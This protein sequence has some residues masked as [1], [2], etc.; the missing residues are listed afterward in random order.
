LSWGYLAVAVIACVSLWTLADRWWPATLFLFGPRWVLLLPLAALI[1]LAL[2]RRA[3]L[4]I[5]LTIGAA[6]VLFPVMGLRLG[7][8]SR[9]GSD[10][11]AATLRVVTFNTDGALGAAFDL[12]LH[13]EE[14]RADIVALQDC[15]DPMQDAVRRVPRWHNHVAGHL[16][17][18]SRHPIRETRVAS[19]DDLAGARAA[20]IGGTSQAAGYIIETPHGPIRFVNLHLETARKGL[21]GVFELDVRR[22]TPN[23]VLRDTES[24]R[25]REWLGRVDGSVII[26][27]D[28]NTPVESPI[29]RRDWSEF[30]NAFSRTGVGFGMTMYNQWT[31]VRIDHILT[32]GH[33]RAR[34]VSVIPGVGL[35]HRPVVADLLWMG[36]PASATGGADSLSGGR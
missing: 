34:R 8:L 18:L 33:W 6:I 7:W 10:E 20:G 16:C 35:D 23:S 17:V 13:L 26:V 11:A 32:G 4:L 22:I 15:R 24:R 12:P 2:R 27:G 1:P 9:L 29:Y 21:Q 14:W 3:S 36:P 28:F 19:W 31:Q 25:T 5:P 30:R